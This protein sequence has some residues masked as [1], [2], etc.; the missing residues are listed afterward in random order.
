MGPRTNPQAR[1]DAARQVVSGE[2]T[3]VELAR[4]L[5]VQP[6]TVWRWARRHADE[7]GLPSPKPPRD[8]HRAPSKADALLAGVTTREELVARLQAH[9]SAARERARPAERTPRH[10]SK[11]TRVPYQDQQSAVKQYL[12]KKPPRAN[13]RRGTG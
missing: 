6:S 8:L 2:R 1:A 9:R 7:H 12:Q 11:R 4:E 5:G 13:S 10:E 3:A